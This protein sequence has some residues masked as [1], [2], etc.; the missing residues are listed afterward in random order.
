MIKRYRNQSIPSH[1][2]PLLTA[3]IRT[4]LPLLRQAIFALELARIR[5][6]RRGIS[7][8]FCTGFALA[9]TTVEHVTARISGRTWLVPVYAFWCFIDNSAMRRPTRVS[10]RRL[11]RPCRMC[12][13]NCKCDEKADCEGMEDFFHESL[14]SGYVALAILMP[15]GLTP[16][17]AIHR[18]PFARQ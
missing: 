1:S 9:V 8:D 4:L 11:S 10:H 7:V 6:W 2:T 17:P 14:L 18:F 16:G 15:A 5:V 13:C 3:A 12:L